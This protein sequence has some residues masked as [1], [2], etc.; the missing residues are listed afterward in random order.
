MFPPISTII[1][2]KDQFLR[3]SRFR[4]FQTTSLSENLPC[5]TSVPAANLSIEFN[6]LRSCMYVLCEGQLTAARRKVGHNILLLV[7]SG[8]VKVFLIHA[9]TVRLVVFQI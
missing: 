8:G 1:V 9:P 2:K 7:G 4:K 5:F 3:P 6:P